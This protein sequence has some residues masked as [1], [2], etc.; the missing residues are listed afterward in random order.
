MLLYLCLLS[1]GRGFFMEL[2]C[3]YPSLSV[4]ITVHYLPL[5]FLISIR[6]VSI[7]V[8]SLPWTQLHFV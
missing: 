3:C 1:S 6:I 8:L 5:A 7:H 4:D 2:M